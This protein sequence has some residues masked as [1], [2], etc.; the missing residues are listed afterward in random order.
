MISNMIS[1]TIAIHILPK[2][3]FFGQLRWNEGNFIDK[4]KNYNAGDK[5]HNP[6]SKNHIIGRPHLDQGHLKLNKIVHI[7]FMHTKSRKSVCNTI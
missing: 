3:I 7:M 2:T 4:I 5:T 1:T 6:D